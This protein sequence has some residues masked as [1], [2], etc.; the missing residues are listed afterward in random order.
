MSLSEKERENMKI[1]F[2]VSSLR[3][4][5]AERTVSYLSSYL[6]NKGDEVVIYTMIN[7]ICYE[8]NPKIKVISGDLPTQFKNNIQRKINAVHRTIAINRAIRAE[9]PDI[10]FCII[11]DSAKF[12]MLSR[13]RKYK[14]IV[15]ERANPRYAPEG[16][17]ERAKKIFRKSDGIIFQTAHVTEN[18]KGVIEGKS[19]IIPNAVGNEY[20]YAANAG[21]KTECRK[22]IA[23]VGRLAH[24]KDYFV[25][26]KAFM[27][28]HNTHPD[29]ILEIYGDGPDR[30]EIEQFI[31]ENN[32]KDNVILRGTC[33][34]VLSRISD[35]SCYILTSYFEGMPNSLMEA[36]GIGMPCISTDCEYGPS[37]LI[38]DGWNGLLVP[39]KD[40]QAIC[41]ALV[42]MID[43]REF[44][45]MC[46][47]NAREILKTNNIETICGRYREY[48]YHVLQKK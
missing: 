41:Q 33:R 11:A 15:S 31:L 27:L 3:V 22:S 36:M 29:Y 46:G 4:G 25:M 43:D 5:G 38:K 37:E 35:A 7:Q 28:F 1:L 32:L 40:V 21:W 6:A 18:Y 14:V 30:E 10:V 24:Q 13:N 26:I 17:T 23:A 12:L 20:V 2:L 34:D 42:K 45:V 9:K 47:K 39:V 44:A 8:I 48:F 16:K 19:V